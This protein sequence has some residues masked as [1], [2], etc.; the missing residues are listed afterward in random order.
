MITNWSCHW[1]DLQLKFN[2]STLFTFPLIKDGIEKESLTQQCETLF[3]KLTK[4]NDFEKAWYGISKNFRK[5]Y[6]KTKDAIRFDVAD[7]VEVDCPME[8]KTLKNGWHKNWA[9]SNYLSVN[10]SSTN[11]L[12]E[13]GFFAE[14]KNCGWEEFESFSFVL[15]KLL[16]INN[17]HKYSSLDNRG[18]ADGFFK[19]QNLSV[20]YDSTLE[21]KFDKKKEIQINNYLD[22]IKNDKIV[23]RDHYYSLKDTTKQVWIISRNTG[24]R[25]I[26]NEDGIKVKEIGYLTLIDLYKRRLNEEITL[27]ELTDLLKTLNG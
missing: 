18:K 5:T 25:L 24:T 23:I 10:N 6:Y 22:Q 4:N 1:D 17:I 11:G 21:S 15:L 9:N 7:L 13:P 14:M 27:D 3:I 20:L 19:F 26:R 8:Y 2:N 16:G 12:L